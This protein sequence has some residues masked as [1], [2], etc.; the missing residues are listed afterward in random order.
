[1]WAE[2]MDHERVGNN[3]DLSVGLLSCH[4]AYATDE[5]IHP[6]DHP[7]VYVH[8]TEDG[9]S[10]F[11]ST[12]RTPLTQETSSTCQRRTAQAENFQSW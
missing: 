12:Q 6:G 2:R 9:I 7:N 8:A 10:N 3:G 1:M 4:E 11:R 5:R